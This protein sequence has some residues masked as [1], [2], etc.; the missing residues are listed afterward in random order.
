[1]DIGSFVIFN[2]HMFQLKIN[3]WKCL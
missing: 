3:F 1:M 2:G